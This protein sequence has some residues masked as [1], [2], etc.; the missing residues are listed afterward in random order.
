MRRLTWHS[1][2]SS[3]SFF[4]ATGASRSLA[5]EPGLVFSAWVL[6]EDASEGLRGAEFAVSIPSGVTILSAHVTHPCVALDCDWGQGPAE[7]SVYFGE[8]YAS[9]SALSLVRLDLLIIGPT[10]LGTGQFC[11]TTPESSSLD[12]P[13]PGFL[14][15]AAELAELELTAPDSQSPAGCARAYVT[16]VGGVPQS[17]GTL[18]SNHS[19]AW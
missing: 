6:A 7:W 8:C 19:G 2:T 14:T 3:S 11:V 13:V 5:V 16:G 4:D 17:W 9:E 18:K 10:D 15:C 12:P 1:R